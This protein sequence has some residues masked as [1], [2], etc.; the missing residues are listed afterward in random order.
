MSDDAVDWAINDALFAFI[1]KTLPKGG[2]IL[3]LGSG[4]GTDRLAEH[5]KMYSVE[6][7]KA[8]MNKYDS[9]YIYAPLSW[10]KPIKNHKGNRW[11]DATI[12]KQQIRKLKYDLILIDGPPQSRAGF[13]KYFN[14]FD[15]KA[16]MVFDDLQRG[17]EEKIVLSIAT[18]L[19]VPYVV[20]G[21]GSKK[22]FGVINDPSLS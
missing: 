10:H 2:T 6:H 1:R 19:K 8:W 5:Y 20:Y 22:L 14:M 18:K 9:N 21:A 4:E 12:L 13:V 7:D 11:Y 17:K 16:I 15:S 3:E